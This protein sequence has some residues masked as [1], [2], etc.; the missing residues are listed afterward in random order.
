MILGSTQISI[1]FSDWQC[2]SQSVSITPTNELHNTL[3]NRSGHIA[4]RHED[5]GGEWRY[6]GCE[7]YSADTDSSKKYAWSRLRTCTSKVISDE[8]LGGFGALVVHWDADPQREL[9]LRGNIQDYRGGRHQP[10][11]EGNVAAVADV[12]GDWREEIVTSVPG[13]LRIYTTT[14]PATDRRVCL[15]QN[16]IY[17]MDVVCA[18]MGYYQV[19]MTSYDL[20]TGKR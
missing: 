17:R 7:C 6:P 15:M 2:A 8:N 14:I 12:L 13:E 5:V 4:R 11:I 19:P 9:L 3:R 10:Q 18:A 1:E 16:T 20:A